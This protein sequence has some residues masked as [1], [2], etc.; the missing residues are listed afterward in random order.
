MTFEERALLINIALVIN[1]RF[2]SDSTMTELI[3]SVVEYQ[4]NQ[5]KAA[6]DWITRSRVLQASLEAHP[7]G[8]P[9]ASP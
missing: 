3:C 9:E 8:S 2:N 1:G 6:Q 4:R 5:M 7:R